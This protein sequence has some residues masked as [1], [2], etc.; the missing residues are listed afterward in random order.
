M[1]AAIQSMLDRSAFILGSEVTAFEQAFAD[2][3]GVKHAIG[4][5]SGTDA[6]RLGLE[7]LG[8]GP[9]DEVITVANTYI[10]TC[11]AITHAG[12]EVRLVDADPRTY[13]MDPTSIE[14]A[15]TARAKAI[16]PVHLYG[17]PADMAPIMKL[18]REHRLKVV[19]DCAQ[20]HGAR[21]G[22]QR[23]GTFGDVSCFSFYPGKNLGAYGDAGAVVTNDDEVAEKVRMLS[24]HG[25]K[26]KYEHLIVGYC[27]RLDN[28][29]AAVLGV[30]LPHLDEW[31]TARRSRAALYDQLLRDVPGIVT[32]Y[33][34][35]EAEAV[36]HLYVIRVT[37][38]RRDGLQQHL[39]A[40]GVST[41]LHYPIPVHLQQAYASLGHKPG[42]FPV[43]E[44][45][46]AQGLSL[47]MYPELADEQVRYVV[48]KVRKFM[49][50]GR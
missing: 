29:Q 39:R 14:A 36:Y 11:E 47:P 38:G 5:G 22:G 25:Q 32:P 4:V 46:A 33:V 7:G 21:Y 42:D 12:A 19:E 37:D 48:D 28:L 3:I 26:V 44:K 24:N 6:L 34:L 49:T 45:L 20:S 17:Q 35:P 41:G 50:N 13:N 18:A 15:L 23:T 2:Y 16:M 8:V 10:A 9:G 40:A 27:H 1:D 30:K 43:S 31:N